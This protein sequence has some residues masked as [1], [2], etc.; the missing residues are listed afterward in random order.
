MYPRVV[1]VIK[2]SNIT[3]IRHQAKLPDFGDAGA[4]RA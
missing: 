3:F 1:E 2:V 4:K